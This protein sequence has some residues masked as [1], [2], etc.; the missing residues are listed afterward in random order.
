LDIF[1][2]CLPTIYAGLDSSNPKRDDG[3]AAIKRRHSIYT[4]LDSCNG[5]REDGFLAIERRHL[6][7]RLFVLTLFL[8]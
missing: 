7:S 6:A 4:G 2:E 1:S 3:F 5:K 8:V